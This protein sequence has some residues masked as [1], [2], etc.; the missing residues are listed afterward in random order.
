MAATKTKRSETSETAKRDWHQTFIEGF[1]DS[2]LVNEACR[3][4]GIGRATAYRHRQADE[5]FALAWHDAEEKLVDQMEREAYRRAAEG[6]DEPIFYKGQE[7]ATVK[8]YSDTLLIFLL[9]A[10]KPEVF[11]EQFD[12]RISGQIK[13]SGTTD[14]SQLDLDE[15][16]ELKRLLAKAQPEK[17]DA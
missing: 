12:H 2:G 13:T 6:V 4:A 5:D 11:R 15:A 17:V 7:I 14:L 9:K 8:K 10:R 16:Q 3:L 1:E